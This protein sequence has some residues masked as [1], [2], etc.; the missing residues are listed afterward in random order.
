MAYGYV[1]LYLRLN[2]FCDCKYLSHICVMILVACLTKKG[3]SA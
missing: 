2:D 1:Y 3:V